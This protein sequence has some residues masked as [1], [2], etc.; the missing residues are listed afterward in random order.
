MNSFSLWKKEINQ[1]LS[2]HPGLL[3]NAVLSCFT[4]IS[5]FDPGLLP[6]EREHHDPHSPDAG[7]EA[8]KGEVILPTCD[9]DNDTPTGA[10]G[11]SPFRL[12]RVLP[13]TQAK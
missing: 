8:Q 4:R 7:S 5:S 3:H 12:A 13:T 1:Q 11:L 10:S 9:R 6:G 2:P